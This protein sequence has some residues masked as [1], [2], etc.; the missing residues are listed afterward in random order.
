[1]PVRR[2]WTGALPVPGWTGGYEWEGI[3]T[4]RLEPDRTYEDVD[5]R[6]GYVAS[7][8]DNLARTRRIEQ[9]LTA[10]ST[11]GVDDFKRMQHD[12]LA[13]NAEQLVPLLARLRASRPDVEDVRNGLLRWDRR[14]T[15]DSDA[16]TVYALWEPRL[17]RAL[18]RLAVPSALV[19]D[20]VARARERLVPALTR[21]SRAWF[22]RNTGTARDELLLTALAEAVDEARERHK[23]GRPPWGRLHMALF[24]HPLAV[25]GAARARFNVG[26][27]ERPGYAHTVMSTAG[28]DVEQNSGASFSAIFDVGDW[29]RSVATNAPGQSGSPA[30]PRFADLAKL[31][32]AGAYFP[33]LFS[34]SAV[35]AAADTTLML[36][37]SR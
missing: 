26:P 14:L 37:P 20:F 15:V 16:A 18:A 1:M 31:W 5:P 10:Q 11:F 21:P 36:N 6:S 34:D 19:D 23:A 8:N 28:V 33:L 12:T 22:G 2:S 7:A 4:V 29:D 32:A 13:W 25:T 27:F 30:S 9:L 17:L 3:A 24:R 35:Q